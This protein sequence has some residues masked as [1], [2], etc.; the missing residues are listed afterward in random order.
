MQT[1]GYTEHMR[2]Y[3]TEET[4]EKV[5]IIGDCMLSDHANTGGVEGLGTRLAMS[6]E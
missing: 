3:I 4:S 1:R 6:V 2:T 5:A